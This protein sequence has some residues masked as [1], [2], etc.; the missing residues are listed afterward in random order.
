MTQS[1]DHLMNPAWELLALGEPTHAEPRFGFLRNRLF[2]QLVGHGY[3]SLALESD[4]VAGTLVDDFVRNGVGDLDRVMA[5]GF[6]HGFGE[7]PA[8]RELVAWMRDHNQEQAPADRLAWYGFDVPFETLSAPSPRRFL[9]HALAYLDLEL[10]LGPKIDRLIGPEERWDSA[11]ALMNR[12]ASP[13]ASAEADEL[14]NLTEDLITTLHVRAPELIKKS[15]AAAWREV[16]VRL[17]A[18]RQLLHYH[19]QAAAAWTEGEVADEPRWNRMCATRDAMM[20]RNLIELRTLEAHRGP[21]LVFANNLHLQRQISTMQ[22][23]PMRLEWWGAGSIL[24]PLLGDRYGFVAGSLGASPKIDLGQPRPDTYESFLQTKINDWGLL[25]PEE[26]PAAT[27]RTDATPRQGYFPLD[28]ETI[29]GADLIL[30]LAAGQ[31]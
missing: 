30:H 17:T 27:S 22:M 24:A 25:R 26:L 13:G 31:A 8:N 10:D 1:L 5:E 9:A 29:D 21:T 20:A 23:G 3:R 2:Q 6:S 4:R 15:S 12:E 16:E 14:R 7:H 18:A 11:A 19:G 28:Q